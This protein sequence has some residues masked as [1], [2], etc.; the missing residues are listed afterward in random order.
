MHAGLHVDSG[1][2]VGERKEAAEGGGWAQVEERIQE[3][4][5]DMSELRQAAG[6]TADLISKLKR[7]LEHAREGEAAVRRELQVRA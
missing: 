1:S 4:L 5:S 7:D 2:A 6:P 3:M